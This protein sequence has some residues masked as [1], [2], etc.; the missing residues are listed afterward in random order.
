[1]TSLQPSDSFTPWVMVCSHF[2]GIEYSYLFIYLNSWE[3]G[4]KNTISTFKNL[5][6]REGILKG[7]EKVA[8]GVIRDH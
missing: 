5:K 1:M 3:A 2:K 6:Q 4:T 7:F 8:P